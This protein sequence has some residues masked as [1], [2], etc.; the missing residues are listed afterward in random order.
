MR[1]RITSFSF[2]F[3]TDMTYKRILKNDDKG[4]CDNLYGCKCKTT[5]CFYGDPCLCDEK[6]GGCPPG[7]TLNEA[8]G[9]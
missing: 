2:S 5:A 8:G 1:S 4:F 3:F 7:T 9:I 6:R